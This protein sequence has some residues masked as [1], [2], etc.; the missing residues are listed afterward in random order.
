MI[1]L[2]GVH[3]PAQAAAIIGKT[4]QLELYDLTPALVSP[5]VDATG[6]NAIPYTNLYNLLS[7]VAARAKTNPSGFVLFKPVK[8]S[9]TTGTGKK[10]K[11]TTKTV[12]VVAQIARPDRQRCIAIRPRATPGC[13]TR[14]AAR[15]RPAGRS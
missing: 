3:D 4:A 1:Q 12:Y 11:T 7:S 9:S 5:S 15:F 8:I 10:T 6:S 14:T 2:A 13:S